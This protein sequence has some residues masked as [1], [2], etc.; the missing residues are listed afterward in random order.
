MIP[1]GQPH[2]PQKLLKIT[3]YRG[4]YHTTTIAQGMFD[5]LREEL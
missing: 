4:E 3:R 1:I 5:P 2:Q